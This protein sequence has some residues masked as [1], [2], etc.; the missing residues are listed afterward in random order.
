MAKPMTSFFLFT[1]C[2]MCVAFFAT[3]WFSRAVS[4]MPIQLVIDDRICAEQADQLADTLVYVPD[5]TRAECLA[6]VRA[7]YPWIETISQRISAQSVRQIHLH[8][9]APVARVNDTLVVHDAGSCVPAS[10][11]VKAADTCQLTCLEKNVAQ[12]A[13]ALLAVA[14]KCSP[15]LLAQY[16]VV[17]KKQTEIWFVD[18]E[19]EDFALLG[20]I[21]HVPTVADGLYCRT[22]Y[23]A[24]NVQSKRKKNRAVCV[25][26]LRFDKQII[27][28]EREGLLVDLKVGNLKKKGDVN[29]TYSV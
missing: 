23:E 10:W 22:L 3:A 27:F 29:V 6:S 2:T 4:H 11:Y 17:F 14:K 13:P 9:F 24:N 8:A 16:A 18:K 20:T 25:A 26:D 28:Y 19:K 15:D 1:F 7:S 5:V 12:Q 21:D